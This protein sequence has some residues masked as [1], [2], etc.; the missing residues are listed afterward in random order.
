MSYA[1]LFSGQGTQHAQ[2]WPWLA[3]DDPWVR[4][5]ESA[6]GVADWRRA[7]DDD[8]AWA[9]RNRN[10][11]VLLTGLSLAA[12]ARLSAQ[13]PPPAVVAGYSVGE[14]AAFSA[15]GVFDRDAALQLAGLRAAAMDRC[16]AAAPGGLLAVSGL[17]ASCIESLCAETGAAVAIRIDIDSVVLGGSRL[18]LQGCEMRAASL[19]AKCTR[20]AVEVASHTPL[21]LPA[22][23]AFAQ[24]LAAVDLQPPGGALISN[25]AAE[26]V[27]SADDARRALSQQIA[28]TV[29][30]S[31]CLEAIHARRV[32]CVLELGPG[33]ALASMW[34]RRYPEVPARSADEFRSEASVLQWL[35]RHLQRGA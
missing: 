12:W 10:A 32:A 3:G 8:P 4:Q 20:L 33:S 30:W 22:A 31:D 1:L 2:M 11:Q 34:N 26:R 18:S 17:H 14:V 9:T 19:G 7:V 16:A 23:D 5:T 29:L 6:L 24:A 13:L 27:L 28:R 21:M 35:H 15:A 25:V